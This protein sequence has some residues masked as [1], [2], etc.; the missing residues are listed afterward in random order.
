ME[1]ARMVTASSVSWS[2]LHTT[3]LDVDSLEP[4]CHQFCLQMNRK[5][6][7]A[8]KWAWP[9]WVGVTSHGASSWRAVSMCARGSRLTEHFVNRGNANSI[10]LRYNY[11]MYTAERWLN[12][13]HGAKACAHALRAAVGV[14]QRCPRRRCCKPSDTFAAADGGDWLP[15][16][17]VFLV[18]IRCRR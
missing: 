9:W 17:F 3:C 7:H 14:A 5:S 6:V 8:A 15:F 4:V 10:Q 1:F 2:T 12:Q 16:F 18:P 13:Q 11:N